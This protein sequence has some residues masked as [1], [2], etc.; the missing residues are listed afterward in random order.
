MHSSGTVIM[1]LPTADIDFS[2]VQSIWT[3]AKDIS[4]QFAPPTWAELKS[5]FELLIYFLAAVAA[6]GMVW[7]VT[8][9]IELVREIRDGRS[10]IWDLRA[11]AD[12]L[13]SNLADMKQAKDDMAAVLSEIRDIDFKEALKAVQKQ[14]ADIQRGSADDSVLVSQSIATAD[15]PSRANWE[16]IKNIWTDAR[17]KLD[18]IIENA[19]GRKKR[20]YGEVNRR[21]YTNIINLLLADGLINK[22]IADHALY[23][24]D[25]YLSFRNQRNIIT[26]EVKQKFKQH[27]LHFDNEMGN[28]K[29]PP[30]PPSTNII[31]PPRAH[32]EGNG[33]QHTSDPP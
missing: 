11:V 21:D 12:N 19:D 20:K 7:R 31:P 8:K 13:R 29:I 28:Y 26:E 24:N 3:Q 1:G 15:P 30:S 5:D 16:E 6:L 2:I 4:R 22:T 23:M 10:S 9:M 27:K 14:L 18:D 25:T 32:L 17:D 33:A